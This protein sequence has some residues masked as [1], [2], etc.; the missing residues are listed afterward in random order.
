MSDQL[1]AIGVFVG[2]NG[3]IAVAFDQERGVD[4][5]A[6]HLAGESGLGQTG[7]DVGGHVEHGYR[8]I[9]L[10]LGTIGKSY[11]GHVYQLQKR[12]KPERVWLL[13]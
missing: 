12:Q 4:Q 13:Q 5:L 9:E 11:Y 8:R 6:V 10:A 1:Q 3:E 7:A 2:N